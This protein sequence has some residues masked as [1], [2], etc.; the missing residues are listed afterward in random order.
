MNRWKFRI[1]IV[2]VFALGLAIGGLGTGWWFVHGYYGWRGPRE[3]V[4]A[5]IMKRLNR[6]LDLTDAQK[7]DLVPIVHD[8]SGKLEELRVRTEPEIRQILEQGLARTQ[9]KLSAEQYQRLE[10]RY[11]DLRRRWEHRH[12]DD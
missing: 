9:P 5:H 10:K 12:D 2:L 6:Y 4:E 11:Q 1:G 3:Q 8:V 7:A